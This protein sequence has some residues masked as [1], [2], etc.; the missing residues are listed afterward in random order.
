M[1]VSKNWVIKIDT[2]G[3]YLNIHFKLMIFYFK[4]SSNIKNSL[5]L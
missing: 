5:F 1:N 4:K 3:L 2:N